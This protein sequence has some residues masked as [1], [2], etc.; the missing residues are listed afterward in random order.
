[1]LV[2]VAAGTKLHNDK[3]QMTAAL[4]DT[5][6]LMEFA[7]SDETV[8]RELTAARR[9]LEAGR[10]GEVKATMDRLQLAGGPGGG[11][12][13]LLPDGAAPGPGEGKLPPEAYADLPTDAVPY[14][15]KREELFKQFL[16]ECNYSRQL[17]DSG[18]DVEDLRGM[19][20]SIIEAARLGQD[21]KVRSLLDKMRQMNRAKGGGPEE[22]PAGELREQLEKFRAA[23]EKAN[24]QGRDVR[25]ALEMMQRVRALAAEGD[26]EQAKSLLQR[27]TREVQGAERL[28]GPRGG[29]RPGGFGRGERGPM[30]MRMPQRGERERPA[31]PEGGGLAQ[32]LLQGLLGMMSAEEADLAGAYRNVENAI[33]AIREKNG[34]QIR[35]ILGEAQA[36]FAAI[37]ERRQDFTKRMQEA[38]AERRAEA[39]RGGPREGQPPRQ[40]P[41]ARQPRGGQRVQQMRQAA[42]AAVVELLQRVRNLTDEQFEQRK[43]A[44]AEELLGLL[45]GMRR[46]Q[47]QG[48]GTP[49]DGQLPGTEGIKGYATEAEK[50]V[51]EQRIRDKLQL[52]QEPFAQLRESGDDEKLVAELQKLFASARSALYSGDYLEAEELANEGLRK[53]GVTVEQPVTAGGVEEGD[54]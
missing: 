46:P 15:K 31:G 30:R 1:M 28:R 51:A 33:V 52:A 18:V 41:E 13:G 27:A 40:E 6:R 14:F 44:I 42:G 11:K 54:G 45:G 48:E 7:A 49:V 47:A 24:E 26:M 23:A 50:A 17:R 53:L 39:Q 35:E 3:K 8:K 36:H 20:D 32:F 43:G 12:P 21:D 9:S 34:E 10:Y 19:R 25:P 38:M 16:E 29:P 22:A 2:A 4:D 37:A 5:L